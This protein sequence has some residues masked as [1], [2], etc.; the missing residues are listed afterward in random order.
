MR[1]PVPLAERGLVLRPRTDL[2]MTCGIDTDR[3]IRAG[4]DRL[5]GA[6]RAVVDLGVSFC[7][8]CLK[9]FLP[10]SCSQQGDRLTRSPVGARHESRWM[11]GRSRCRPIMTNVHNMIFN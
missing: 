5:E 7:S 10:L 9:P 11:R 4:F 2:T 1:R 3:E 6:T 8:A